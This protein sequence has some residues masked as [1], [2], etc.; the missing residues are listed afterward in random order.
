MVMSFKNKYTEFLDSVTVDEKMRER[1]IK[2]LTRASQIRSK[3]EKSSFIR[4]FML[5]PVNSLSF[6]VCAIIGVSAWFV[7]G[8]HFGGGGLPIMTEA[9]PQIS[10]ET[11]FDSTLSEQSAENFPEN[12]VG[13]ELGLT[14]SNRHIQSTQAASN[15]GYGTDGGTLGRNAEVNTEE[16]P[17]VTLPSFGITTVTQS[18]ANGTIAPPQS[19]TIITNGTTAPPAPATSRSSVVATTRPLPVVTTAR[20]SVATTARPP[21]V[22][23]A[24]PPVATTVP[25]PV[26]VT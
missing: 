6:V 10:A 12:T 19:Q 7:M 20:P 21:V 3:P 26:V 9:S 25:P 22:T 18:A 13:A 1:T 2:R 14:Q 23:T 8:E 5:S 24:L 16:P 17:P 15:E 4:N 11:V